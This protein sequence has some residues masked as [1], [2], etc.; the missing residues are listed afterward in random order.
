VHPL[1]AGASLEEELRLNDEG[2]DVIVGCLLWDCVLPFMFMIGSRE[3][4]KGRYLSVC[5]L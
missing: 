1:A 4:L 3:E 5:A 2:G